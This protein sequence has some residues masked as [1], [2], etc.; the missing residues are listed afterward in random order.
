MKTQSLKIHV[1]LAIVVFVF[2]QYGCQKT[3]TSTNTDTHS[4]RLS[5]S[6]RLGLY[7]VDKAGYALYISA[8]DYNGRS[9][10]L[11]G[12]D[13]LWPRFYA[14]SLTQADLDPGL[15]IADFDTIQVNGVPQTRYKTW[16][17]YYYAP[18]NSGRNTR[19]SPGQILGDGYNFIWYV[20]K[21][22]YSIMLVH[23]QLVGNDGIDYTSSDIPGTGKT[24]YFTDARGV[25]L[26]TF[27]KDSAD[28]NEFTK[29]DFSN[30]TIWPVFESPIVSVPSSLYRSGFDSI[31]VDGH[32]QI[33]Y[34]QWPLYYFGADNGIHGYNKGVSYP[35]P[36][37][38]HVAVKDEPVAPSRNDNGYWDY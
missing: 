21:P 19:E 9:S 27:S 26:Y 5:T 33:T 18:A 1:F 3:D 34:N 35:T 30:N 37:I 8:N 38:W 31:N 2:I 15:D 14:G 25:A 13:A 17:L 23:A 12:C 4:V 6:S 20:A 10:C 36:G 11:T 16:P 28:I 29:P 24:L 7:L 22:D 32:E